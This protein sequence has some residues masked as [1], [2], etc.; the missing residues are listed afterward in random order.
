MCLS[1]KSVTNTHTPRGV[2]GDAGAG[3]FAG[4]L[5]LEAP[6]AQVHHIWSFIDA[7]DTVG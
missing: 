4:D 3:E 1:Y 7:H 6:L 5:M 2:P